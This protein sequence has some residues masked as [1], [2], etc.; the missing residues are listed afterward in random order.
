MVAAKRSVVGRLP[1][2]TH[3]RRHQ[4]RSMN[5]AYTCL[6]APWE[7][8]PRHHVVK[9]MLLGGR[10]L[11]ASYLMLPPDSCPLLTEQ[12]RRAA[13]IEH[14]TTGPNDQFSN[15]Q[16]NILPPSA[17]TVCRP[18]VAAARQAARFQPHTV[19]T[20]TDAVPFSKGGLLILS[21]FSP[22]TH[23]PPFK[24]SLRA[25]RPAF[26]VAAASVRAAP[27][28]APAFVAAARFHASARRMG[29]GESEYT[30]PLELGGD[31]SEGEG[32]EKR[33][34]KRTRTMRRGV[35]SC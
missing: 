25:L 22:N 17:R 13:P 27:R 6:D 10:H 7:E 21:L 23:P 2:P 1:R 19:T 32:E 24:M 34:R 11:Y 5:Q 8:L 26:R 30:C 29:S 16:Y 33:I 12:K 4:V 20:R 3:Y 31:A 35:D 15:G 28:A 14:S 9:A 18:K